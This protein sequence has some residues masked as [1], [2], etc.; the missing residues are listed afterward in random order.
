MGLYNVSLG[1]RVF[2]VFRQQLV[3]FLGQDI[4]FREEGVVGYAIFDL[5]FGNSFVHQVFPSQ[6]E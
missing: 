2:V 4:G 1:F 3:D 6:V 5:H